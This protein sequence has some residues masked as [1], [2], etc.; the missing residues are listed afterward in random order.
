MAEAVVTNTQAGLDG[1]ELLIAGQGVPL[2]GVFI[3]SDP[4]SPPTPSFWWRINTGPPDAVVLAI[5]YSGGLVYLDLG[6]I[7]T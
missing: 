3:D 2:M 6:T 7:N 1:Q 4:T 5:N